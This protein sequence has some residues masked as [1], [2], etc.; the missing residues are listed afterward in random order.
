MVHG[1]HVIIHIL[2]KRLDTRYNVLPTYKGH[3]SYYTIWYA[4]I[5]NIIIHC[6]HRLFD[7]SFNVHIWLAVWRLEGWYLTLTIFNVLRFIISRFSLIRLIPPDGVHKY[8]QALYQWCPHRHTAAYTY[9]VLDNYFFL[10]NANN[11]ES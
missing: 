1:T 2:T 10:S 11:H 8:Y 6:L 7:C 3:S 4:C 5:S 9:V